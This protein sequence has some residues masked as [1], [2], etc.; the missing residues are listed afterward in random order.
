VPLFVRALDGAPVPLVPAIQFNVDLQGPSTWSE[1]ERAIA[2]SALSGLS[3]AD[4]A[5]SRGRSEVTVRKQLRSAVRKAGGADRL[6]LAVSL[7]A[8]IR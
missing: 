4:I 7:D 6:D 3:I 1:T 5:R 8:T 2:H